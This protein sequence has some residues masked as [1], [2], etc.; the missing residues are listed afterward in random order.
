[1]KFGLLKDIKNG[2]FR[3]IVT[4]AEVE[5]IVSDGHEVYV[6]RGA[7]LGAGFAD[8]QYAQEGAKLVDTME[9]IYATCDLVTKVK[10]LEPCEFPCCGK[11]R[12]F[13]PVS[14]PP[15]IPRRYRPCWTAKHCIHC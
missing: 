1:M 2:E 12:S 13:S 4:P 6:Q 9:K 5:A 14:I 15:P 8:E 3:T 11:I 10:E 7:G